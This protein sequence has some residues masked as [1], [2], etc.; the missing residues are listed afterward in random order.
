MVDF[1]VLVNFAK[2]LFNAGERVC[3]GDVVNEENALDSSVVL[4]RKGSV[5]F[6][7]GGV[8]N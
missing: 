5:L 6:L 7:A 8:P 4:G 1:T 3:V 2:P